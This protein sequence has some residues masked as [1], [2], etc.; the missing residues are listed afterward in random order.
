MLLSAVSRLALTNVVSALPAE[1]VYPEVIPGP[2]MPSLA[3]IGLTSKDLYTMV[4]AIAGGLGILSPYHFH[5]PH[6][7][8]G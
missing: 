8:P 3:S 4:P 7:F 5:I 2:G 6:C 1:P